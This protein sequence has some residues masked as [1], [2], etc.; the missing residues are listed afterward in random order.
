MMI[1]IERLF[2]SHFGSN[3]RLQLGTAI[4][5][6][7]VGTLSFAQAA[8]AHHPFGGETPSNFVQ[9]LLS[10]MGHPV[11]GVD[12]LAFVIASGLVAAG[13]VGGALIPIAFVLA[14]VA[15]TGIHLFEIDLPIPELVIS[16]S[17]ILF[18]VLLASRGKNSAS[19][20]API[21]AIA[22]LAGIFHGY[23]YGEA[24][25]G[26]QMGPLFAYLVGFAIVQ[27]GISAAA[28]A[29]G[30]AII[31][32]SSRIPV[33]RFLGLAIGAVGAVFLASSLTS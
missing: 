25:V 20:T 6:A 22:A 30:S 33:M 32:T 9:G 7:L 19:H 2:K 15:G 28:Y 13:L 12:H 17:V 1:S 4:A 23:A 14:T 10:G 11:I 27:L 24:I 8:M 16:A 31:K 5:F 29:I 26:A 21:A 18:G 3:K